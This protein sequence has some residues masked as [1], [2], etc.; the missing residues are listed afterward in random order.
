MPRIA[1]TGSVRAPRTA[2]NTDTEGGFPHGQYN[3]RERRIAHRT[4]SLSPSQGTSRRQRARCR[5]RFAKNRSGLATPGCRLREPT[6]QEFVATYGNRAYRLAMWI[7]GK[8]QDAEEAVQDAFWS[9][10]RR[11]DTFRGNSAVGSWIYR[12]VGNAAYAKVRRRP[13]DW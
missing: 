13:G 8:E 12:I 9:V 11:I 7:T 4:G 1:S 5:G 2:G 3:V 10:I 6:A